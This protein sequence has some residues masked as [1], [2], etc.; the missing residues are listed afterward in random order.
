MKHKGKLINTTRERLQTPNTCMQK[1]IHDGG[2][3]H[4]SAC[5]SATL[6]GRGTF[7]Y[8][9][10]VEKHRLLSVY[11]KQMPAATKSSFHFVCDHSLTTTKIRSNVITRSCRQ[12]CREEHGQY[13]DCDLELLD[14]H[15]YSPLKR[16]HAL[17]L[18]QG[19]TQPWLV[20]AVVFLFCDCHLELSI[21]CTLW[22]CRPANSLPQ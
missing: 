1:R 4:S 12:P 21:S 16:A 7:F 14:E 6:F 11:E 8:I 17:Q 10:K 22:S 20:L 2:E 9:E 15:L 3:K 5:S 19:A 18:R 13:R